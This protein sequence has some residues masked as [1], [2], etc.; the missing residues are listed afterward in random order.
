[1]EPPTSSP[2][3]GAQPLWGRGGPVPAAPAGAPAS[4]SSRYARGTRQSLF[5]E[6]PLEPLSRR[7]LQAAGAL[8]LL[9]ILVV[10]NSLLNNDG[11]ESP[12]D[13]NPVAA[14]AQRTEEVPGMRMKL[15]MRVTTESSPPTMITGK[16]TLQRR[17]QPHRIRL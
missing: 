15:W 14:A 13:P 4:Q 5:G 6:G 1:M 3:P 12:F 17:R 11:G 8:S 7:L 10:F 16:G 9:L 2:P